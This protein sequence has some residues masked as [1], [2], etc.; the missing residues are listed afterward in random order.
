MTIRKRL[1]PIVTALVVL[2]TAASAFAVLA[3]NNGAL[4]VQNETGQ[5]LPQTSIRIEFNGTTTETETDDDGIVPLYIPGT[6]GVTGDVDRDGVVMLARD[7][8]GRIFYP[9]GPDEGEAFTVE[10]GA[11]HV[12]RPMDTKKI[13]MIGAPIAAGG[14]LLVAATGGED[15]TPV[16]NAFTPT[17]PATSTSPP[18]TQ[19]SP[20]PQPEP[21]TVAGTFNCS[22]NVFENRDNIPVMLPPNF[23]MMVTQNGSTTVFNSTASNFISVNSSG[24][25]NDF[26]AMGFGQYG[27]YFT[28]AALFASFDPVSCNLT[29]F[30]KVNYDGSLPGMP[31]PL[32]WEFNCVQQ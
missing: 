3:V 10:D 8:E 23:T 31:N 11:I 30:Y 2:G 13:A 27:D 24:A 22:F 9:G 4:V 28:Q 29:G 21:K 25:G 6:T 5:A 12:K 16:N 17:P 26:Q 1:Q 18:P 14:L 7:G 15:D 19:V 32:A 20:E